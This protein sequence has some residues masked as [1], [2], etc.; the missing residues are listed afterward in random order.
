MQNNPPEENAC[1]DLHN[2]SS[3]RVPNEMFWPNE[4]GTTI[5]N[6]REQFP[7]GLQPDLET[8]IRKAHPISL[9]EVEDAAT[10]TNFCFGISYKSSNEIAAAN[11][12]KSGQDTDIK[13]KNRYCDFC[14]QF[15]HLKFECRARRGEIR[16]IKK[17]R[18]HHI[19]PISKINIF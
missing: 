9:T 4:P 8:T 15:K 2:E 14:N 3:Y 1:H 10:Q 17:S 6:K 16:Q 7:C 5:K 12:A 13:R 18:K 19:K 11:I